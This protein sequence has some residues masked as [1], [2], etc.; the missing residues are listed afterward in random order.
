MTKFSS[1]MVKDIC[2]PTELVKMF[3]E[4]FFTISQTFLTVSWRRIFS[5]IWNV[6]SEMGDDVGFDGILDIIGCGWQYKMAI[7]INSSGC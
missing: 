1:T 6:K 7:N 3:C 4:H 2:I 5:L